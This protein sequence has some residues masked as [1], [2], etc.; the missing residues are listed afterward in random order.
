MKS[1]ATVLALLSSMLMGVVASDVLSLTKE[2]FESSIHSKELALVE[3]FGN[4]NVFFMYPQR[5]HC[6]L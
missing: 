4:E 5:F 1:G 2:S 3:F 6:L